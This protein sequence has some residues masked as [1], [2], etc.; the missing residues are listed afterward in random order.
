MSNFFNTSTPIKYEGKDSTNPLSF[1]YYDATQKIMGKTMEEH[2]RFAVCYWHSF[3][4]DGPD[5]FG[6]ATMDRPWIVGS[7]SAME[8]AKLKAD[9]AFEM[10]DLLGVPFFTFH[11]RDIAP[12]GETLAESNRNVQE[13][14]DYFAEKC[15][16]QKLAYYGV[17]LIY[18]QTVVL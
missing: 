17:R 4:W 9:S 7:G 16:H 12:E 3:C 8:H 2:L 13:I 15:N 14:A 5:P 6:G 1:K 10:Y 18:F 11:D